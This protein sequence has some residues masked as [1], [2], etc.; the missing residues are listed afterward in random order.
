[1]TTETAAATHTEGPWIVES[2]R[3][4]QD[5]PDVWPKGDANGIV[6]AHM[7]REEPRTHPV[8]RDANAHLIAA[9][10]TML[11]LLQHLRSHFEGDPMQD[12]IDAA[13][14]RAS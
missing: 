9:A 11:T 8:E 5:G 3:V 13:I 4:V 6:I 7:D 12:V 2:G 14:E 10:P 1:M